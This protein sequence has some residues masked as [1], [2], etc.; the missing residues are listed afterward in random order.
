[1]EKLNYQAKKQFV[2][3]EKKAGKVHYRIVIGL[4]ILFVAYRFFIEPTTIGH[5]GRYAIYIF[6]IPTLVGML[7]LGI[8]RREFLI[9]RFLTNKGF[10]LRTFLI[11]FYL[12]QG[13]LFSFLSFG[14]VAKISWDYVNHEVTKRNYE[15][16][17]RCPITRFWIGT[18]ASSTVDF[19]FNGRS[20]RLKVRYSTIKKY[21]EENEA[22][23]YLKIIVTKGLWNYYT[24]KEWHIERK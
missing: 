23:Y 21:E 7:V 13:V 19:N 2:R 4:M 6:W 1:M 18:R 5:D 12:I 8:Y 3:A 17:L 14:Q 15:E 16:T 11:C 10:V 22:D 9:N 24:V 20:E